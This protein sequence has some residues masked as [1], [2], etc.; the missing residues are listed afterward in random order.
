MY[1][2]WSSSNT[3]HTAYRCE[4]VVQEKREERAA[5]TIQASYRG[6]QDRQKV[7]TMKNGTT[8]GQPDTG[9]S[10]RYIM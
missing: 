6:F 9:Q 5:T 1:I 4:Q 7:K 8:T 2:H 10:V 3:Y